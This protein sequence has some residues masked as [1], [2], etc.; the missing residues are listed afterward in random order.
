MRG[1]FHCHDRDMTTVTIAQSERV[2][3]SERIREQR[4]QAGLSRERLARLAGCSYAFIV[5]IERGYIPARS[6]VLP[7]IERV[8]G[9][10][11]NNKQRPGPE[12]PAA[13]KADGAGPGSA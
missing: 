2:A 12:N 11:T 13:A 6:R 3:R 4:L 8:L 10:L 7:E 5:T 1:Q 9:A